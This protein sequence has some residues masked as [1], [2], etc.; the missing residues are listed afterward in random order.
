MNPD[1]G[2]I[3]QKIMEYQASVA[4]L[5]IQIIWT[6]N[7]E[8]AINKPSK[9]KTSEMDKK[10][11]IIWNIMDMLSKLCLSDIKSKVQRLKIET[12]VTVHVHQ[13]DLFQEV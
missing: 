11:K 1:L 5:G 3:E 7:T 2:Y 4:L 9:D 10:R 12:L 8:E 6:V 13:R